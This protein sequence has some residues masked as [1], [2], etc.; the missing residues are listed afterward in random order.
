MKARLPRT[1]SLGGVRALITGPQGFERTVAFARDEAP[2]M[3]A[4]P[5]GCA[6]RQRGGDDASA[7]KARQEEAPPQPRGTGADH[8]GGEE[9][10]GGVEEGQGGGEISRAQDS[11]GRNGCEDGGQP[12]PEALCPD[13]RRQ[14][15]NAGGG[16]ENFRHNQTVHERLGSK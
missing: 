12:G 10:V 2:R 11:D 5:G 6:E 16:F 1:L 8:R 4:A 9:A 15:F 14:K 3:T 13:K 7:S